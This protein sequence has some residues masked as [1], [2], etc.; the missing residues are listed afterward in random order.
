MT[1]VMMDTPAAVPLAFV[2]ASGAATVVL[3]S[4]LAYVLMARSK[5]R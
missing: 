3:A 2:V 5:K 1:D 4:A